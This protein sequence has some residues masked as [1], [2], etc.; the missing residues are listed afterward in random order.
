[1]ELL[2]LAVVGLMVVMVLAVGMAVGRRGD[3]PGDRETF[4]RLF[5]EGNYKDAYE[6][7]RR[8]A[9]DPK[10]Q[11]DRVGADLLR[12]VEC[13]N[14][15]GRIAESD[16]FR[17]AVIAVHQENWRLLQA[18]AGSYLNDVQHFGF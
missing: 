18:A 6:G 11:P 13:L 4:D 8:L 16:D 17:E 1:M 15:L 5:Q 12:G 14:H 10:A 9:L 3:A 7:Y 2:R